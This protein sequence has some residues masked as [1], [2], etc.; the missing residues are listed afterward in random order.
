M[1]VQH[2]S[3]GGLDHETV[4]FDGSDRPYDG[5]RLRTIV[6]IEPYQRA[7]FRILLWLVGSI[8]A[9]AYKFTV[10]SRCTGREPSVN[11]RSAMQPTSNPGGAEGCEDP[12]PAPT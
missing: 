3:Q 4:R 8:L 6:R 2:L 11:G 10:A 7:V 1:P 5:K 12:R 9:L